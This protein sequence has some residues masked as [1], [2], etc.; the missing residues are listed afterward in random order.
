ML[1]DTLGA[2]PARIHALV[3]ILAAAAA[4]DEYTADQEVAVVEQLLAHVLGV[5]AVPEDVKAHLAAVDGASVDLD[6]ACGR[7]ALDAD[8][9]KQEL[10]EAAVDIVVADRFVDSSELRFVATL[11]GALGMPMPEIRRR[12]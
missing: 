10:L 9:D 12:R 1:M 5:E 2:D 6:E 7:L 11:A 8:E 3:D 4:A